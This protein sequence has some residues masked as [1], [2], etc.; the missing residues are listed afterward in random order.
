MMGLFQ[1]LAWYGQNKPA[2]LQARLNSF[3]NPKIKS[4][5]Q[6]YLNMVTGGQPKNLMSNG[7][8]EVKD[9]E[10]EVSKEMIGWDKDGCPKGWNSWARDSVKVQVVPEGRS[11]NA[12]KVSQSVAGGCLIQAVNVEEGAVYILTAYMKVIGA[13]KAS[14]GIRYRTK[15]GRWCNER[16]G[17]VSANIAPKNEG[18]WTRAMLLVEVP[19]GIGAGQ[20]TIMPGFSG[21]TDNGAILMDDFSL[22]RVK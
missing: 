17:E 8:F 15:E 20:V 4:L 10:K 11:G 13:G 9:A 5:V 18:E 16:T 12:V 19:K 3:D 14:L 2:E 7:D 1:A 21:M 6:G 22:V